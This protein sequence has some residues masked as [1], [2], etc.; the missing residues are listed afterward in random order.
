MKTIIDWF[1]CW[2]L[3]S[4]RYGWSKM[5]RWLCERK[6]AKEHL[7]AVSSLED[8]KECLQQVKWKQ[9]GLLHLYD[10]ISYPQTVWAKKEDDCDGFAILAAELLYRLN[11]DYRPVMI[12]SIVMPIARSH[13]VCAFNSLQGN[14]WFF[15]NAKLKRNGYTTFAEIAAKIGQR[16]DRKI[17]WDV[18]NHFTFE[19]IEF[20][21]F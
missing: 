10:S 11:P 20:K 3:R 15:D 17:C 21:R 5:R 13:T 12:T 6:F 14:L 19:M 16:G 18:R 2:W 9:E 8:V 4:G 1:L 7:P